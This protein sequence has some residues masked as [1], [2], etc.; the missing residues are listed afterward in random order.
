MPWKYTTLLAQHS[1]APISLT[2]AFQLGAKSKNWY[3]NKVLIITFSHIAVLLQR[4]VVS[5]NNRANF[6]TETE[7]YYVSNSFIKVV[8]NLIFPSIQKAMLRV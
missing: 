2:E 7:V 6:S 5:H 8:V 4:W 1:S 3:L